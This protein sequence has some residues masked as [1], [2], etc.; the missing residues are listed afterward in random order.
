VKEELLERMVEEGKSVSQIANIVGITETPVRY[1]LKKYGLKTQGQRGKRVR[2]WTDAEMKSAL[3]SSD[4]IADALRKLGLSLSNGNYL[5]IRRFIRRTGVGILHMTGK[6]HGRSVCPY[7]IP[8]EEIL[9]RESTY[10]RGH[11]KRRL[12]AG[13]ILEEKCSICEQGTEWNGILLKMILDHI[14]GVPDDNRIGNLRLLCPNCNSQQKTHCIGSKKMA[15][16][17]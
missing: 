13:G 7:K 10:N 11:L 9:V 14:N 1:W 2:R 6:A 15:A 16:L 4:T 17:V 12:I 8:L 5:T 3:E